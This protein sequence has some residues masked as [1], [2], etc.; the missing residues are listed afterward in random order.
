MDLDS[1]MEALE[2][3]VLWSLTGVGS[4]IS[5]CLLLGV[6]FFLFFLLLNILTAI[7]AYSGTDL[8]QNSEDQFQSANQKG[9]LAVASLMAKF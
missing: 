9:L 4:L 1:Q 3:V 5:V 6:L 2:V 8:W 7:F